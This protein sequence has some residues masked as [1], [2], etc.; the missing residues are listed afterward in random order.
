MAGEAAVL[1]DVELVAPHRPAVARQQ[2]CETVGRAV[3]LGIRLH[4]Q[5][6]V[7]AA[8]IGPLGAVQGERL[9]AIGAE[10]VVRELVEIELVVGRPELDLVGAEDH[11]LRLAAGNQRVGSLGQH[12]AVDRRAQEGEAGPARGRFAERVLQIE[13]RDRRGGAQLGEVAR[14][15]GAFREFFTQLL[16]IGEAAVRHAEP[17]RAAFHDRLFEQSPRGG[18]G[19]QQRDVLRARAFADDRHVVGIATEPGDVVVH[20]LERGDLV[21]QPVIA[22]RPALLGRELR[23]RQKAKHAEAVLHPDRDHALPRP[24]RIRRA[25]RRA[26]AVRAAV[27]PHHDRPLAGERGGADVERQAILARVEPFGAVPAFEVLQAR[28]AIVRRVARASPRPHRLRCPPAQVR[29]RW[30]GVG[31]A[32]EHEIA[33]RHRPADLAPWNGEHRARG[34]LPGGRGRHRQQNGPDERP[35]PHGSTC[36][37]SLPRRTSASE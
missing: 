26:R 20:P 32:A 25:A 2:I 3:E 35:Q 22:A 10:P 17:R 18:R 15:V 5:R 19:Q 27:D 21:H 28:G 33:V 31:D 7:R 36:S 34:L 1:A 13:Q 29:Q 23:R 16:G 12:L 9:A 6:Q 14:R 11:R 24:V 8:R 37:A 30:G 4:P